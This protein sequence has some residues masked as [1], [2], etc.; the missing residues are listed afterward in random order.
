LCSPIEPYIRNKE[1][2]WIIPKK[3]N[4]K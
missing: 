1:Y 2:A 3:V 4:E